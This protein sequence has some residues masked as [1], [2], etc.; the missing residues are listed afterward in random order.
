[1][2]RS[3]IFNST[4]E[5]ILNTMSLGFGKEITDLE[6]IYMIITAILLTTIGYKYYIHTIYK[7]SQSGNLSDY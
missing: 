6:W 1:M 3:A 5:L 7:G 4:P 2:L